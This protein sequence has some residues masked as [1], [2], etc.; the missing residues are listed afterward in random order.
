MESLSPRTVQG[1]SD[2]EVRKEYTRRRDIA[3]KRA[4]RIAKL[5]DSPILTQEFPKIRNVESNQLRGLL[6]EV[7]HYLKNPNTTI[8]G[9]RANIKKVVKTLREENKLQ[10]INEQNSAAFGRFMEKGRVRSATKK[11]LNSSLMARIFNEA[12]RL[13]MRAATLERK[14]NIYNISEAKKEELYLTLTKMD[15]PSSKHRTTSTEIY[16]RMGVDYG[17]FR[18]SEAE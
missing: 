7:S 3:V 13:N 18:N 1:M 15:T 12:E 14:F 11:M 2:Q 16:E 8:R 6:L 10:F 4:K 5:T 17:F 9:Y